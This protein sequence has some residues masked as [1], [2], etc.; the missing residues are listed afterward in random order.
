MLR[1][2]VATSTAALLFGL[3]FPNMNSFAQDRISGAIDNHR[4][5]TLAGNRPPQARPEFDAGPAAAD[6]RMDRMILVLQPDA[7]TQAS[8]DGLVGAQHDTNSPQFQK[9]LDPAG[10]ENQFGVSES[11]VARVVEWLTSQGFSIDE[12]PAGRRSIVFSGSV[13][14]V[15][16]AFHTQIRTYRVAGELHHANATDPQIPEALAG[17]VAGAVSMHDFRRTAMH[18]RVQAA[19]EYTSGGAHYLAPADF[20]SIYDVAALYSSGIT[21]SGQ[22]LAIVGRTNIN[23][24]DVTSF[25]SQFGLPANNPQVI[26]NGTNP[27]IVSTDEETEA[28]L[29]V[30]WS[31]AVAEMATVKFVVSASTNTTDG[32][33]L[34][35]QYIVS[36]N[37]APVVSVSFGSCE[38]QMGSAE[39]AFYTSLWQQAAAQGITAFIASGDSGAAGCDSPSE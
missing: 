36:N 11:D 15:E 14:Q 34:S 8:L 18:N 21:G 27:G 30:E 1:P 2:H 26:V 39:R 33:D 20:A 38:S 35:A 19:P 7:A 28:D 3:F 10:F 9:W 22:T 13:A 12:I 32:V 23:L 25:R 29:D 16:S 4:T 5:V 31:G 6:F 17:V 24:S 37:L